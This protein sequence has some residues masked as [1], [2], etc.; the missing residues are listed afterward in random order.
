MGE[1]SGGRQCSGRS[2]AKL[3]GMG[4][5]VH[6]GASA[7]SIDYEQSLGRT[8]QRVEEC[9]RGDGGKQESFS[10]KCWL[11]RV[12]CVVGVQNQVRECGEFSNAELHGGFHF[13]L[14]T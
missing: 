1:Q 12:G 3:S 14:E 6:E 7:S 2:W 9:F 5:R 10:E 13:T 4:L 8:Q 11:I